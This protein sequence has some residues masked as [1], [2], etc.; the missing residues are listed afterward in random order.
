MHLGASDRSRCMSVGVDCGIQMCQQASFAIVFVR[1]LC[2]P[3][4]FLSDINCSGKLMG[5]GVII[6]L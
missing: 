6:F 1:R 2:V 3:I 5:M 4:A